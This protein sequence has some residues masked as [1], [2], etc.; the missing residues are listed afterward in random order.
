MA[1]RGR[2]G[3]RQGDGG[4]ARGGEQGVLDDR[5]YGRPDQEKVPHDEVQAE[6]ADGDART[7]ML[8]RDFVHVLANKRQ[9]RGLDDWRCPGL[10]C[11]L[12]TTVLP[13]GKF[14]GQTLRWVYEQE[15]GYLAWFHETVDGCEEVKEAIRGLD[16]IEAH[17]TRFRQ[18]QRSSP[19]PLTSTQQ[20]VEW[21][22]GK[23]S[24]ET[25]DRV[26]EELFGGKTDE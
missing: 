21:L 14:E 13:F 23:F 16:G 3:G 11:R 15:P 12:R 20:Q 26:C 17:L 25:V 22:M 6:S 4:R 18:K 10:E 19:K 5:P 9:A 7:E 2:P 1:G 24:A 8:R